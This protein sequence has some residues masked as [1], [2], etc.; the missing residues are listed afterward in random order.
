M[1]SGDPVPPQLLQLS[2]N[3][4]F[5][6]GGSGWWFTTDSLHWFSTSLWNV[7][8]LLT[9]LTS[10]FS[11]TLVIGQSQFPWDFLLLAE[12]GAELG[13]GGRLQDCP[14]CFILN[15]FKYF[16]WLEF[17]L[18]FLFFFSSSFLLFLFFY[19]SFCLLFSPLFSSF[20]FFFR[21]FFSWLNLSSIQL[22]TWWCLLYCYIL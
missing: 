10:F 21:N 9:Q 7:S 5:F 13:A 4:L 22:I 18:L 6:Q 15:C 17:F 19:S 20:F 3:K 12:S 8:G 1:S 2:D 14:H 11:S 16:S